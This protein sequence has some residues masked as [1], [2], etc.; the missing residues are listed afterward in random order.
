VIG[1]PACCL[2]PICTACILVSPNT[3]V[4][5]CLCAQHVLTALM[6]P[7]AVRLFALS[8]V[9]LVLEAL[10][11]VHRVHGLLRSSHSFI[12]CQIEVS[13]AT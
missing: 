3:A 7:T 9:L 13:V 11:T 4:V 10:V 5:G 12:P 2:L 1:T 8:V 6:C